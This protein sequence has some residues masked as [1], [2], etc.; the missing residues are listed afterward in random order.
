LYYFFN[1]LYYDHNFSFPQ[2]NPIHLLTLAALRFISLPLK[3]QMNNAPT[4]N[5]KKETNKQTKNTRKANK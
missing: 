4:Q 2:T 1:R 5:N 3:Q